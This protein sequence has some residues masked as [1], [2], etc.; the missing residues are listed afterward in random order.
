MDVRK[1]YAHADRAYARTIFNINGNFYRSLTVIDYELQIVTY[2]A[3]LTH[4]ESDR[5][6]F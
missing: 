5:Y 3:P 4:D 2:E 6:Q 1:S